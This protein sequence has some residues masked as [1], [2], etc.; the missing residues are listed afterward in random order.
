M[1]SD[2]GNNGK[3]RNLSHHGL[4]IIEDTEFSFDFVIGGFVIV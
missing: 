1:Q 3:K 2:L 4:K